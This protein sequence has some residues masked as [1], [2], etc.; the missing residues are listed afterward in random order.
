MHLITNSSHRND[1]RRR[2]TR[3]TITGNRLIRGS[4]YAIVEMGL[5][6]LMN[7][8]AVLVCVFTFMVV[9]GEA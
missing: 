4:V 7:S 9:Q 5:N 8:R 6:V 2:R 3:L 1:Y